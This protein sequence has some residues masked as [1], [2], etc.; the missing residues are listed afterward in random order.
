MAVTSKHRRD[1]PLKPDRKTDHT[2]IT[3]L[4]TYHNSMVAACCCQEQRCMDMCLRIDICRY[5]QFFCGYGQDTDMVLYNNMDTDTDADS[6]LWYIKMHPA[7][8]THEQNI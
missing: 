7:V 6:V 2:T 8:A 5:P 1:D 3:V 4:L